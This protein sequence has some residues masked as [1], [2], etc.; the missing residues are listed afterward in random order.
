MRNNNFVMLSAIS[1]LIT[2]FLFITSANRVNAGS[3]PIEGCSVTINKS[4]SP[5]AN[6]AFTF[7]SNFIVGFALQDPSNNSA[8]YPIVMGPIEEVVEIVPEN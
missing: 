8:S 5:A 2:V 3:G 7:R 6:S 4:V 1:T